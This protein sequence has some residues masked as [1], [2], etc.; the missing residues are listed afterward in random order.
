M[1]PQGTIKTNFPQDTETWGQFSRPERSSGVFE[2]KTVYW[3]GN[4]KGMVEQQRKY[5]YEGKIN[6]GPRTGLPL[7]SVLLLTSNST[8]EGAKFSAI[9]KPKCLGIYLLQFLRKDQ[10]AP[11]E[12]CLQVPGRATLGFL[13]FLKVKR[14]MKP[15]QNVIGCP[16][17]E[18]Q[19]SGNGLLSFPIV[20]KCLFMCITPSHFLKVD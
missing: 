1:F 19:I 14:P 5:Y 10:V 8:F 4:R 9:Q 6:T 18:G 2:K 12:F 13:L 20:W 17:E 11:W 7:S 3:G 16:A 15:S